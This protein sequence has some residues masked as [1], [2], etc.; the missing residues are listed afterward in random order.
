MDGTS[1][2]IFY[3]SERIG[4]EYGV[5]SRNQEL[6]RP[7]QDPTQ[8]RISKYG[9]KLDVYWK[10]ALEHNLL[11]K[12]KQIALDYGYKKVA[13]QA[14]L[15]GPGIQSNR[16]GLN[17]C[18]PFVF[19]VYFYASTLTPTVYGG[20]FNHEILWNELEEKYQLPMVPMLLGADLP[21]NLGR[22]SDNTRSDIDFSWV[23]KLT[24][25]NGHPIEGVV[26]VSAKEQYVGKLG[27]LKVKY[28]NPEFLLRV[29]D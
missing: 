5:C 3:D 24:Y 9:F 10:A 7:E 26:C 29:K 2:T 28:V 23:H 6:K 18:R 21:Y 12:A 15:C 13:I 4:D 25:D 1:T 11:E 17:K 19:D 16:M 27:R 14:E 22:L 8:E 20:Y